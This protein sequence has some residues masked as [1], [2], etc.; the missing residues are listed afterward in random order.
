M[1]IRRLLGRIRRRLIPSGNV[2]ERAVTSGIWSGASNVLT[3][4]IQLTKVVVLARLL[5][6]EEFGLL[7]IAFL[8]LAVFESFSEFGINRALIQREEERVDEY[9]NTAWILQAGRGM[10]LAGLA[11]LA[12]PLA[13]SLFGEPRVTPVIR[14]IALGKLILGF[15]NPAIMYFTKNLDFH[16]RFVQ[17]MSGTVVNFVVAITLGFALHNVWALVLGSIAG[18]LMSFGASFALHGFRPSF[19]FDFD[20]A[21]ELLDYGKWILG[22]N[23]ALFLANQGDDAF[24]GWFL[25]ATPLAFYQMAYRFSNAPATEITQVVNNVVF[26]SYSKVQTDVEKLRKGFYRTIRLSTFVSFPAAIGIVAIAPTFVRTFL[27]QQW[28]PTIP[29]MQL[30]AIWGLIRSL[31]V[32]VGPLFHAVGRPDLD[33][34]ILAGRVLLIALAIYPAA[35]RFGLLGVAGVIIGSALF[36]STPLALYLSLPI[37]EGTA[38]D[39]LRLVLPPLLGSLAMGAGVWTLQSG[40]STGILLLDFVALVAAGGAIYGIYTLVAVTV[41]GYGI[42]SELRAVAGAFV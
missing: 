14:V 22:L 12:A 28:L 23:A 31:K 35:D 33:T 1:R 21:R 5:P 40:F 36:Y 18:N 10:L 9:L 30:L 19:E 26:P 24:V 37:V 16:K 13:A 6:P 4:L 41:F 11:F 25:G 2:T 8:T 42:E 38:W 27:G 32:S 7:G 3:R 15:R 20:R 29:V 39:F 34:K 17:R